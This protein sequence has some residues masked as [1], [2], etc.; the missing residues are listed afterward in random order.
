MNVALR[1]TKVGRIVPVPRPALLRP[2]P[3][4][5]HDRS[6]I[7]PQIRATEEKGPKR[8]GGGDS[9]VLDKPDKATDWDL[10]SLK[11]FRNS[12]IYRLLLHNDDFNQRDYVVA[13]LLK[14]V[15]VIDINDA[16]SIM[17]ESHNEGTALV[18][19]CAQEQAET[20]CQGLRAAGLKSSIEP[21]KSG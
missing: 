16:R 2:P 12:P 9:A 11:K 4:P 10:S 1:T 18:V 14:V 15:D 13:V 19:A 7:L 20:Y 5:L 8:E 3:H 21:D 17:E 6:H